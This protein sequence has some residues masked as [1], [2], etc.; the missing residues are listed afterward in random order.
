VADSKKISNQTAHKIGVAADWKAHRGLSN[1]RIGV[2]AGIDTWR[3]LPSIIQKKFGATWDSRVLSGCFKQRNSGW[4]GPIFSATSGKFPWLAIN[5]RT[6][7]LV[8]HRP[9]CS[10]GRRSS[11]SPRSSVPR[12]LSNYGADRHS[13]VAGALCQR[14]RMHYANLL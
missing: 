5:W 8:I 4:H 10:C 11:Q 12:G 9:H 6:F 13:L 2:N 7:F 14:N 3:A 1:D